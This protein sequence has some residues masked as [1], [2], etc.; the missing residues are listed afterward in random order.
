MSLPLSPQSL[1][2]VIFA[3]DRFRIA[4][5]QHLIFCQVTIHC[6]RMYLA[7]VDQTA[8]K[9]SSQQDGNAAVQE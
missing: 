2:D 1:C 8:P 7:A 4:L 9:Q 6:R 5:G 3:A